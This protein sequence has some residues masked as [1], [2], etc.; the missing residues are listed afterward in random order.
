[1]V[2]ADSKASIA[3][4]NK[5]KVSAIGV[6]QDLKIEKKCIFSLTLRVFSLYNEFILQD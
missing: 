4:T 6:V 3:K 5:N 2:L 1:M